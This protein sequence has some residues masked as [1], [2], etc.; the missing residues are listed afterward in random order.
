M[1]GI[2]RAETIA[3]IIQKLPNTPV[4]DLPE[5]LKDIHELRTG[6]RKPSAPLLFG[7]PSTDEEIAAYERILSGLRTP[8]VGGVLTGSTAPFNVL[9][10][11]FG[12]Q[13]YAIEGDQWP[14]CHTCDNSL[15]FVCQLSVNLPFADGSTQRLLY[16]IYY[17]FQC[18]PE[19]TGP[20]GGFIIGGY[21]NP[22]LK[23]AEP[24]E[25]KKPLSAP[26][27]T[28]QAPVYT[29]EVFFI[30]SK[31]D[32]DVEEMGLPLQYY[33]QRF[34][35]YIN[36]LRDSVNMIDAGPYPPNADFY[37]CDECG[38]MLIVTYTI[39]FDGMFSILCCPMHPALTVGIHTE[40]DDCANGPVKF[41]ILAE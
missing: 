6:E 32:L 13:P 5:R 16:V 14:E 7:Y 36:D 17:C 28:P 34:D 19:I 39:F 12:G 33:L 24:I 10:T 15:N 35:Q 29:N 27:L 23:Q 8:T 4:K 20:D 26:P 2:S 40:F 21:W 37:A 3:A 41:E 1:A 30:P 11:H 22:M 18:R 38:E 25:W 31:R 9:A